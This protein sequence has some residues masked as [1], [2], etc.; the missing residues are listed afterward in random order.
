MTADGPY[1]DRY[2][3]FTIHITEPNGNTTTLTGFVSDDTGG[4]STH[5]TPTAIGTYQIYMTFPGENLTGKANNPFRL[6][7]GSSTI[8]VILATSF[9]PQQVPQ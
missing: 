1:G 5:F 8:L 3:P 9:Y 4:T 7:A 2:G 6:N